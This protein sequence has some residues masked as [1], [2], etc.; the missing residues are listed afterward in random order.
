MRIV[1]TF[2][3]VLALQVG[4]PATA[5]DPRFASVIDDLPLME[6]LDEMGEG[7]QFSTPQGRIAEVTAVGN[8]T[9][10]AVLDFYA[11]TLPQLGWARAT[12]TTFAREEE[13]LTLIIDKVETGLRVRFS[14]APKSGKSK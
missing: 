11:Q 12:Q 6:A 7:M 10:A 3:F 8:A 2:L 14:L 4:V 13:I 1:I 5:A 9:R